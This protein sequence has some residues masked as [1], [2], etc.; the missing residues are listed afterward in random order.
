MRGREREKVENGEICCGRME[1]GGNGE[2]AISDERG[3]EIASV[4]NDTKR[5]T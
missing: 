4:D 2:V 5:E 3:N 1:G